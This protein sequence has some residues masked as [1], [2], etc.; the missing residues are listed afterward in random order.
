MGKKRSLKKYME[1][2]GLDMFSKKVRQNQWCHRGEWP[3]IAKQY[4]LVKK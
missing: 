3:E 4:R 1:M 2:V